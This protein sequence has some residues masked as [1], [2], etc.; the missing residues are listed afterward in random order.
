MGLKKKKGIPLSI[1]GIKLINADAEI[2]R[3]ENL[4]RDAIE[5][6][7]IGIKIRAIKLKNGN[8]IIVV[9]IPKSWNPPHKVK[10]KKSNRFYLRNSNGVYEASV[11]ELRQIFTMG[12]TLRDAIIK[13]RDKRIEQL[14]KGDGLLPEIDKGLVLLHLVPFGA[15]DRMIE[16]N[17]IDLN[18]NSNKFK[19]IGDG[20]KSVSLNFDGL[21][22][23]NDANVP[24]SYTQIFR[25]GIIE[26][27]KTNLYHHS[28]ENFS[29]PGKRFHKYMIETI[30][31][32]LEQMKVFNIPPPIEI[33][34]SLVSVKG[35]YIAFKNFDPYESTKID[36]V[37][38]KLPEIVINDY[39]KVLDYHKLLRP[40]FDRFCNAVGYAYSPYF[41]DGDIFNEGLI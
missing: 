24:K 33:L 21:L 36:R 16:I 27:A 10:F 40:A 41:T 13:F 22:I 12:N 32:F 17:T 8:G 39:G 19:L 20:A 11:E 9:R 4:I 37:N 34:I 1:K 35:V 18:W 6:R 25:N 23:K 7:I 15:F 31:N 5:P 28:R 14:I 38:L 29:I 26:A 2:L 30:V 3:I